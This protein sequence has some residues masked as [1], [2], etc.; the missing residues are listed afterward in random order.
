MCKKI[1]FIMFVKNFLM[2]KNT[3]IFLVLAF[4]FSNSNL[5]AQDSSKIKN[6]FQKNV[7]VSGQWFISGNY[8]DADSLW[9]FELKRLFHN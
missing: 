3:I 9:Q 1:T 4:L 5:F 8:D 7:D 6:F 2:K